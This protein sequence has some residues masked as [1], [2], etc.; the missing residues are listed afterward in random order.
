MTDF[1]ADMI[2]GKEGAKPE[3]PAKAKEAEV[4]AKG[5]E[6]E[7][8]SSQFSMDLG[9]LMKPIADKVMSILDPESAPFGM[10]KFTGWIRD[11]VLA[12]FSFGEGQPTQTGKDGG[13]IVKRPTYLP[14][15]GVV[16][17]EHP[18]WSGKG[19]FASGGAGQS[20][21]I[22]PFQGGEG[23]QVLGDFSK[24]IA[25]AVGAQLNQSAMDKV[26]LT[27]AVGVGSTPTVIDNSSQPIITNNTIINSPEPQGPMLPGVGRD[28][29]V[30]H[31]RHVA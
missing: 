15:S 30:S 8:D 29:A 2:F 11:K 6:A 12:L 25:N 16:V 27:G 9:S 17:G 31:F 10:G 3:K 13:F 14:S 22:V 19:G 20:E 21:M 26:G 24:S 5:G 18:T 1:L 28:T 23:Q 4:A 7:S